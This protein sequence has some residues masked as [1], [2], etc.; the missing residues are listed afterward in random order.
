ML[1]DIFGSKFSSSVYE[2]TSVSFFAS[3]KYF[4]LD[5]GSGWIFAVRCSNI[6]G[7]LR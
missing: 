3:F 4:G 2:H 6:L 1:W 5:F 7:L